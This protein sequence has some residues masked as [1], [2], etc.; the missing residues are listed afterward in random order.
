MAE[1]TVWIDEFPEGRKRRYSF[2]IGEVA[3]ANAPRGAKHRLA[4][5]GYFTGQ[6]DDVADEALRR[7]LAWYQN[8]YSLDDK[9]GKLTSETVS[10]LEKLFGQ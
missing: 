1:V 9:S 2:P 4:G 8:D 10:E 5:L 6:V 7:A 3:P